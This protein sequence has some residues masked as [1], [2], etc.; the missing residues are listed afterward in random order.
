MNLQRECAH[1]MAR[2]TSG[3]SSGMSIRVLDLTAGSC[4]SQPQAVGSVNENALPA[5]PT[6]KQA[7]QQQ[8]SG[9]STLDHTTA[10]TQVA[11]VLP[12]FS[13]CGIMHLCKH[14]VVWHVP[15]SRIMF[16]AALTRIAGTQKYM[17]T[18]QQMPACKLGSPSS[19]H[20]VVQVLWQQC[21]CSRS[22]SDKACLFA[23]APC[24]HSLRQLWQILKV[25]AEWATPAGMVTQQCM[26]F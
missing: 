22:S 21:G 24:Q 8:L 18:M 14:P 6:G 25:N 20:L 26:V 1:V 7:V 2:H 12:S 16:A 23:G 10:A 9:S 11:N 15:K 13:T 4:A 3:N 17:T 19:T 5:L